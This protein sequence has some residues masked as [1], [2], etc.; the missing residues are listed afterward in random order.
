VDAWALGCT[1]GVGFKPLNCVQVQ[2]ISRE[3]LAKLQA[4]VF[5]NQLAFAMCLFLFS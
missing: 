3:M 1:L 4:Q 2:D 5:F